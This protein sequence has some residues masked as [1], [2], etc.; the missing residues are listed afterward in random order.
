MGSSSFRSPAEF[1]EVIDQIFGLMDSPDM[2]PQLRDADVPQRFEF[3]D[4][5]LVVNVRAARPDEEG[6]FIV[7]EW[8]DDVDWEPKVRMQMASET[9]NKYFQ[10]KENIAMAIA[11]RRIK[12][13]GDIKAALALMPVVKPVYAQYTALVERDYPH[14]KV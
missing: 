3:D 13:G 14:L 5:D 1:R 2:G 4:L 7:W 6:R 10:G 11:R 9:A 8:S 12:T